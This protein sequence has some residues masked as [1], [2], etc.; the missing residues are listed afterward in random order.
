[1]KESITRRNAKTY[2]EQVPV[3]VV[4]K[5]LV[6]DETANNGYVKNGLHSVPGKKKFASVA[7]GR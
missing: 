2:F 5:I 1:M 6:T 3:K 7:G 4:K